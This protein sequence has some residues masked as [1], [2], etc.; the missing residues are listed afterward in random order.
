MRARPA[1][2][3]LDDLHWADDASLLLL[4]HLARSA[5]DAPVLVL[6]TYRET[7]V[8]GDDPLSSA[9]DELRR[10]PAFRSLSLRGLGDEAVAELIRGR[11]ADLADDAAHA[12]AERTE[13]NPF[14]VEEIVR[15]L[16]ASGGELSVPESVKHLLRRRLR[17][18]REPARRGV[19]AAAVL[20]R[21]FH[22]D[23]VERVTGSDVDELLEAL[24]EALSARVLVELP[25]AVGHFGFAHALIRETVY[26]DLS[27]ARRARLHL[28]AGEALE[29][30]HSDQL[31][32]HA[33][34][35]AHHFME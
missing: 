25:T 30:V 13:G 31:D 21:E 5:A 16:D 2:L 19:S 20:G 34:L 6:G 15:H 33:G 32:Q 11:G 27:V 35:V 14:F 29:Q 8:H 18:L 1:I 26:E 3:V 17:R 23:A 28:R 12:V 10:G 22:V 9:L 7:E 24:E 4:R